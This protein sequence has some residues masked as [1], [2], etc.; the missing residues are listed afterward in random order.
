M[1]KSEETIGD[2]ALDVAARLERCEEENTT[3]RAALEKTR[4]QL[5]ETWARAD[6]PLL[7]MM[8]E[9]DELN[10]LVKSLRQTRTGLIMA[11]DKHT[12]DH[13]ADCRCILCSDVRAVFEAEVMQ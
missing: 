5:E 9:R 3:L 13:P 7:A 8:R 10:A 11:I 1:T 12:N 2:V 6:G 4:A